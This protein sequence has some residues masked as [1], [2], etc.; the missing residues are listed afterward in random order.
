MTDWQLWQ[1]DF[2]QGYVDTI[3]SQTVP[4]TTGQSDGYVQGVKCGAGVLVWMCDTSAS[5]LREK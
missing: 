4:I 3:R 1:E 5:H 2:A